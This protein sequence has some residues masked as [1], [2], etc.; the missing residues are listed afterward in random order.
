MKVITFMPLNDLMPKVEQLQ[1]LA[2]LLFVIACLISGALIFTFSIGLT[3][4]FTELSSKMKRVHK[5]NFQSFI[6]VKGKDEVAQLGQIFNVMVQ[7]LGQLVN[8]VY[9]SEIDQKEQALRTKEVEL[10][11]LQTQINPHFLFNI[12]NMIRGK[13]LIA[14]DRENANIV[15]LL[16]KSFRMMLKTGGQSIQLAEEIEFV[17]IYLRL[18]TYRYVDKF[19]Y[20]IEIPDELQDIKIPKL[21]LQPLVENAITHG[22]ELKKT[23]S[24]IFIRGARVGKEI[25]IIVEDDGLGISTERFV[26]IQG[27]LQEEGAITKDTHIGLKNVHH[28][29]KYL[30]GDAFGLVVESVL[31]QGTKITMI[32][33]DPS[34]TGG[35]DLV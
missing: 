14:G 29:L 3:S 10:Y 23:K 30:F 2:I 33:P 12:L 21:C 25:H 32:I 6:E 13:L 28:R 19:Q 7:R 34:I 16:A 8:D 18:Q 15:G 20:L 1:S 17:D 27:W 4:R 22:I 35:D 26:E 11:A 5:D 24:Q 31:G 9:R